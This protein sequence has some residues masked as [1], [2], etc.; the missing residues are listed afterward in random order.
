MKRI[1]VFFLLFCLLLAGCELKEPE[2][3]QPTLPTIAATEASAAPADTAALQTEPPAESQ[4]ESEAAETQ[5]SAPDLILSP[6]RGWQLRGPAGTVAPLV[7][8]GGDVR[9]P[10]F[11]DLDGDK[12]QELLYWCSGPTSGVDTFALCA[13][14]I[15]QGWPVLKAAQIYQLDWGDVKIGVSSEKHAVI[16]ITPSIRHIGDGE[17]RFVGYII[18]LRDGRLLL[19]G[20]AFTEELTDWSFESDY[21]LFGSSFAYLFGSSFAALRQQ[22]MDK[23]LLDNPNC[24]IWQQ[25]GDVVDPEAGESRENVCTYAVVS[26]NG[27]T[28][29]GVFKWTPDRN[30][31]FCLGLRPI[32]S[33][34]EEDLASFRGLSKEALEKRLGP[35]HVDLGGTLKNPCW[36][37]EDGKLLSAV[38]MADSVR[39]QD[40][41]ELF[42]PSTAGDSKD[43]SEQLAAAGGSVPCSLFPVPCSLVGAGDLA[44]RL[45]ALRRV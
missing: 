44:G 22:P 23:L 42:V 15:E 32:P 21:N 29:N 10:F 8:L 4:S 34:S 17:K 16:Q 26:D 6:D 38:P 36:F 45:P 35:C 3:A 24:L 12:R 2:S 37:T 19:D 43:P 33:V 14:G 40:L 41:A 7:F 1:L 30:Y 11:S 28:V 31:P 9:D 25:Y 5:P 39:L 18:T 27:V 13:Y 20:E